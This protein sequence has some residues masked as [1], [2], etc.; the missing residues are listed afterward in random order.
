VNR[1]KVIK[2]FFTQEECDFYIQYIESNLDKFQQ[3]KKT[4]RL[5]WLFGDELS[6]GASKG[7]IKVNLDLSPISDIETKIRDL[8]RRVETV[9]KETYK[10]DN[11]LFITSLMMTK[12]IPGAFIVPHYDTD[13]GINYYF[14]YSAI[15]YLNTM[16]QDGILEFPYLD[17]SYSPE[18]GDFLMFPSGD[19]ES[20]H[21]VTKISEDRYSLPMW[22]TEDASWRIK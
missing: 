6:M 10:N 16:K 8:F 5:V 1:I 4:K 2:N 3:T 9:A 20:L 17:Y 22:L 15:I 13:G 12:Q 7:P 11:D 14:K 18:A 19:K 21:Q